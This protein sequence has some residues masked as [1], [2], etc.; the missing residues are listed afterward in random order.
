MILRWMA[1]KCQANAAHCSPFVI[2][3]PKHLRSDILNLTRCC[4]DQR[5]NCSVIQGTG[6]PHEEDRLDCGF[7]RDLRIRVICSR[8]PS[9]WRRLKA[10]AGQPSSFWKEP[11]AR[12]RRRAHAS[13][14]MPATAGDAPM[15]EM[16]LP[17]WCR[18]RVPGQN[19]R[20]VGKVCK[21]PWRSLACS[22]LGVRI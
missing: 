5:D 22:L 15:R 8:G 3:A 2:R 1:P 7:G 18:P 6:E 9:L 20:A 11:K 4:R 10:R 21:D 14:G 13:Q 19:L 16:G 17:R 12:A